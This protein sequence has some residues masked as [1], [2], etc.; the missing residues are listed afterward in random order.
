VT[1][2]GVFAIYAALLAFIAVLRLNPGWWLSQH[3]FSQWGPR[4]D[5]PCM[6][7][8]ELLG[9]GVRFLWLGALMLGVTV[10]VSFIAGRDGFFEH[11]ALVALMFMAAILMAM[12]FAAGGYMLLR[13]LLRSPRYV[14]PANCGRGRES[15]LAAGE[16]FRSS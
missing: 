7:R 5:V 12:G 4:T 9:E 13:G 14:P 10:T 1:T 16:G 3:L 8:R 15:A 6:T 2:L 11:P